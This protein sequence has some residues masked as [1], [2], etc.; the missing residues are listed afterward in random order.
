[1]KDPVV[2][3]GMGEMGGVFARAFLTAGHPVYPVVRETPMAEL[4]AEIPE[5][6][7]VMITVGEDDLAGVLAELPQPWRSRVGLIQ[8]ELLPRDWEA[9][10]IEDPTVAAVWFEKKPG[11]PVTV[12]IPTPVAG[13]AGG[14]VAG[15]LGAIGVEA[16]TIPG[17]ELID[18]L[19]AKNLYILTAN[20]GGL[21]SRG[22]VSDLWQQHHGLAAAVAGEV[23]D[24]Q[25]YLVGAPVDR[26]RALGTMEE[27]IAAEP[28]HGATG[29][30]APRRLERAL[31][32]ATAAGLD[33]PTMTTIANEAAG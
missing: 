28:G 13:P 20:I 24:V 9:H 27:A 26:E 4:A 16:T 7:V 12:I 32:H 29:R 18:A 14:L 5:P 17:D 23:L 31:A 8:N 3:V 22:T 2:I 11:T 30:S 19:V 21:R 15:A 25:E 10:D 33:V 1:M 6:A